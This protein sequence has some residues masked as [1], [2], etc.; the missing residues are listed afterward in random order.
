MRDHAIARTWPVR[1]RLLVCVSPS[2][3]STRAGARGAAHGG[4]GCG[5]EWIVAYVE[6]PAPARLPQDARDRVVQTLRLAE[7]LGAETRHAHRARAM[8]DEI[9]AFARARNVTKIVVGKPERL[10]AGRRIVVGSI[11]DDAGPGSGEIDV[12][13]ISGERD[14]TRGRCRLARGNRTTEWRAY[15]SRRAGAVAICDRDRVG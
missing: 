10:A 7:Q 1:E 8:S 13:V 2:P 5:A 14:E 12:Y 15:G 3:S 9:L 4:S 11:V 6:T